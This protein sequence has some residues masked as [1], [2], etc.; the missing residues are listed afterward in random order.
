MLIQEWQLCLFFFYNYVPWSTFFFN[1]IFILDHNSGTIRNILMVL[2]RII[3]Q[4]NL[5]GHMQ[6]WQLCLSSFSNYVPWSIFLLCFLFME[7]N[8]AT[9]QN[10]SILLGSIRDISGLKYWWAL[11]LGQ[12]PISHSFTCKNQNFDGPFCIFMGLLEKMVGP[13]ILN[14]HLTAKLIQYNFNGSNT[15]GTM[16]ISSRQE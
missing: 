9:F 8:S 1:F 10:I 3:E 6:E 15:F 4:V 11:T 13:R 12:R 14:R 7:G 5:N 2:G 16:K